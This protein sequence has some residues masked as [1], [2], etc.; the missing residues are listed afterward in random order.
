MQHEESR[1][2]KRAVSLRTVEL[3]VS[4]SPTRQ[5]TATP[6]WHA[7]TSGKLIRKALLVEKPFWVVRGFEALVERAGGVA[8]NKSVLS[9]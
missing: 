2:L 6:L 7:K 9:Q 4:L 3:T 1:I 8:I 5:R